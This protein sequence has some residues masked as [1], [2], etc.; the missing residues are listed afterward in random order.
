MRLMTR[1]RTTENSLAVDVGLVGDG[2]PALNLLVL[3][4]VPP[5]LLAESPTGVIPCEA[6]CPKWTVVC[7]CKHQA[8]ARSLARLNPAQPQPHPRNHAPRRGQQ[9]P[10]KLVD[11]GRL[12]GLDA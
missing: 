11:A 7:K 4:H 2:G 10:W 12:A 6:D 9:P 8:Q 5:A 1:T 3:G